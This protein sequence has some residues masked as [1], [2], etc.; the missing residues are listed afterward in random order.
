MNSTVKS[1]ARVLSLLEYFDAHRAE[2]SVMTLARD[3]GFPQSS[4]SV[5]VRSLVAL[6]YLEPG[7]AARTYRPT[8]RVTLLGAWIEPLLA[9]SGAILQ[10][11]RELGDATGETI[12]LAAGYPTLVRYIHIV[13]ATTAMRLHLSPGTQRPLVTS[14]TGRVFMSTLDDA[15]V[16]WLVYRHNAELAKGEPKVS[17]AALRRDLAQIRADG[18]SVSIDRVTPGAG[19]VAA[20]LPPREQGMPLAIGIGGHSQRIRANAEHFA[21]LIKAAT[22]RHFGPRAV[23]VRSAA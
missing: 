22:R 2:A 19:I 20:A 16:Q 9:P 10:V 5:L 18:Y 4:T 13:P 15:R 1:A 6:G 7:N 23:R 8:A 3:L 14:G 11:M 17:L 21:K 12:I